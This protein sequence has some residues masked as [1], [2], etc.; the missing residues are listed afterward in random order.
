MVRVHEIAYHYMSKNVFE[1]MQNAQIQS[2][3]AGL[4]G[5]VECTF[6]W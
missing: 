2:H 6:D 4:S 5:S 3:I 1:H